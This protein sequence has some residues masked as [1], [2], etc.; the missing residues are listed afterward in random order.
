MLVAF[1][2]INDTKYYFRLTHGA[3]ESKHKL[4]SRHTIPIILFVQQKPFN[5]QIRIYSN[6]A[7]KINFRSIYFKQ[8][9]GKGADNF[10]KRAPQ[11]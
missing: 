11:L 2:G 6:E 5:G 3:P 7:N 8:D 10:V 9:V 1:A 4:Y